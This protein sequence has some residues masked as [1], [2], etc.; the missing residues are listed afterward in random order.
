MSDY[1][2]SENGTTP[3]E[4]R[5]LS[6]NGTYNKS[7]EQF[8][9]ETLGPKHL[10]LA[11]LVPLTVIFSL[12]FITGV[13]GNIS[14]CAVIIRNPSMHTATNYYLFN[15]AISDLNLLILG[16]SRHFLKLRPRPL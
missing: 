10:P 11:S 16:K 14:V 6:D 1:L 13:L 9:L 7:L 15:L 8:L 12:L 3:G 2:V 5:L 4:E